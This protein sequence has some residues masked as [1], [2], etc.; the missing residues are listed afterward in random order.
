MMPPGL[1][2]PRNTLWAHSQVVFTLVNGLPLRGDELYTWHVEIDGEERATWGT[3]FFV[4][5][6]PP[7][8]VIG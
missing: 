5:A 6:P 1:N 3:S 4:A 2:V 7:Q 8:P